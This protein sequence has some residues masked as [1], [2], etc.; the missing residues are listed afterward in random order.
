MS[1]RNQLAVAQLVCEQPPAD[2]DPLLTPYEL[3]PVQFPLKPNPPL[4]NEP[5]VAAEPIET[6]DNPPA[7][8]T[9]QQPTTA[10][11]DPVPGAE[12]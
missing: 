5:I 1:M 2:P 12:S 9:L 4:P 10:P 11:A 6:K 8:P 7:G 3:S